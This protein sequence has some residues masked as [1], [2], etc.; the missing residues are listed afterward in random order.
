M[1]TLSTFSNR[2]R[3]PVSVVAS[4]FCLI[5]QH[6]MYAPP[7]TPTPTYYGETFINPGDLPG[8]YLQ[9]DNGSQLDYD[10][11]L[12]SPGLAELDNWDFNTPLGSF[13]PTDSTLTGESYGTPGI[14]SN[15]SDPA[16]GLPSFMTS[17]TQ[18]PLE[19]LDFEGTGPLIG[20]FLTV[21]MGGY[22]NGAGSISVT[23]SHGNSSTSTGT[24]VVSDNSNSLAM[25]L[26]TGIVLAIT[27][28]R[29]SVRAK[30]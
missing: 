27:V 5:L 8:V 9:Q 15:P 3:M 21:T 4:L 26:F 22:G 11:A 19:Q 6:S 12:S 20:D 30:G 13:N 23:D 10:A 2:T 16:Y 14:D 17:P 1:K 28:P 24:W 25:L 18:I 29:R 7:A